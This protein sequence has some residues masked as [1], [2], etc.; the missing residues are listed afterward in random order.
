[1]K[2]VALIITYNPNISHFSRV[3]ESLKEQVE[4]III[5]DNGS[6]NIEELKL[7]ESPKIYIYAFPENM[8]IAKATNKGFDIIKERKVDYVLLSDQDTIYE[9]DYV[10]TFVLE[11]A[12]IPENEVIAYAP[13]IYDKVT[14]EKKHVYVI[15]HGKIRKVFPEEKCYI[16]HTIA[17][18]LLI[19]YSNYQLIGG[20]NEDLFIDYVDFEWCWKANFYNKK[21]M[22][23]PNLLIYHT[24]GDDIARIGNKIVSKR[25]SIRYYYIIRNT[26]FLSKKTVYLEQKTKKQLKIQALKYIFGYLFLS[27]DKKIIFKAIRDYKKNKVGK[28]VF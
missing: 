5:V 12:T 6:Q 1:M 8:G 13:A 24:L 25:S 26:L 11:K 2:I 9:D 15:N 22:Y 28:I 20:M 17:S 18:G 23:I 16:S 19:D 3:I 10:K 4:N 7:F 14:N 21:I 27:E